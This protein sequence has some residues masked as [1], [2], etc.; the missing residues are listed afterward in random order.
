M[1]PQDL[2]KAVRSPANV[3]ELLVTTLAKKG[4]QIIGQGIAHQNHRLTLPDDVKEIAKSIV[5]KLNLSGLNPPNKADFINT[6]AE[7]QAVKFLIRSEQ[8]IELD[9]KIVIA[10]TSLDVATRKVKEFIAQHGQA[11]ASDL[12]QHLESTR[13]IVMPLLEHLDTLGVTQRNG[14]FRTLKK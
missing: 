4:Y 13:K 5:T 8:I 1:P 10:A 11:T 7:D 3:A 9:A 14:N 6:P 2:H 12:R